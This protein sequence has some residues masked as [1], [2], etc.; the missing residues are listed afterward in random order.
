MKVGSDFG[1]S[2]KIYADDKLT[3][4]IVNDSQ[5]FSVV[6]QNEFLEYCNT[7]R[8]EYPVPTRNTVKTRIIQ[9]WNKEKAKVCQTLEKDSLWKRVG[10]TTD[11]WMSAARRGYIVITLDYI[12]QQWEMRSVIVA[13][14]RVM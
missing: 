4:W 6:E 9:R 1:P 13:F 3:D 5:S 12:D 2:D 11:M 14:K 8:S 10:T 7:L